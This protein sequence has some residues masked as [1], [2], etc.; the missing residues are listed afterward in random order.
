MKKRERKSAKIKEREE[1]RVL[2][3]Q[4]REREYKNCLMRI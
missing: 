2:K 1:E 3:T 4:E